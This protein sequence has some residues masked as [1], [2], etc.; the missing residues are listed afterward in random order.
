MK[1]ALDTACVLLSNFKEKSY[2]LETVRAVHFKQAFLLKAEAV[3]GAMD[4]GA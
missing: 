2:L 3:E 1:A 4:N